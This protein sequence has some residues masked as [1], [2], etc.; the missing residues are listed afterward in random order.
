M[1][2]TVPD[3][4][5][6]CK[7]DK[8]L[9]GSLGLSSEPLKMM[10][11]EQSD[12][13][14][15]SP[16]P[17]AGD[18]S[19][20][21]EAK[22]VEH[23]LRTLHQSWEH[24]E[25]RTAL[26]RVQELF[27][28]SPCQFEQNMAHVAVLDTMEHLR[29]YLDI[30]QMGLQL[31]SCFIG[32]S[33]SM[34]DDMQQSNTVQF[35][36]RIL[37]DNTSDIGVQ[38]NGMKILS[39]LLVPDDVRIHLTLSHKTQ[40][41]AVITKD[42][43]ASMDNCD[44]LVYCTT[45]LSILLKGDR[46]LQEEFVKHQ[47]SLFLEVL[48]DHTP[49]MTLVM[50]CFRLLNTLSM[51]TSVRPLLIES[52]V[53]SKI[54]HCLK[55]W[56]SEVCVVEACF[57]V[58][59]VLCQEECVVRELT[60]QEIIM[61][62]LVPE[63]VSKADSAELQLYGL[64]IF[65]VTAERLLQ[66]QE[67]RDSPGGD[68]D[69]GSQ[70]LKVIYL[71]MSRQM[72][73]EDVQL[74]AC[75]ALTKLL[76]CKPDVYIWIGESPEG[77]QDPIH[78]LCLGA[79][80]M[81]EYNPDLFSAASG[82]I[83]YLTADNDT[84][85]QTLME[86]NTYIAIVEGLRRHL[87]NTKAV[88]A[89]CRALRGLCIFNDQHKE[90]LARYDG[91]ILPLLV[92]VL[93]THPSDCNVQSEAISTIACLADIDMI[94]HQCFVVR[95][96]ILILSAMDCFPGDEVLQEA[97]IEALAVLGGAARGAELLHSL[98]A[99]NK[100]LMCLKRFPYSAY[101]QKKGL[102]AVQ[103]LIDPR[104]LQSHTTCSDVTDV[105]KAAM[106]NFPNHLAIQKEAVVA[107]QILAERG[108]EG[109]TRSQYSTMSETL[110]DRGCHELL[111][112]ILERCDDDT[113]LHDLASECLY[114]IGIEQDLKS[115]MLVAAC[116][117]GFFTGAECL[118]EIGADVNARHGEDTPLY[119][120]V[121]NKDANMVRLLLRQEVRDV[122]AELK[123]SLEQQSHDI[124][125]MLLSH[126]GQDREMGTLLWSGYDLRDLRPEWL[127][128]SIVAHDVNHPASI[129]SKHFVMKIRK[130]EQ[131]RNQRMTLS[132]SDSNLQELY[133]HKCFRFRRNSSENQ[134]RM[135]E[136]VHE[137]RD[138][139]AKGRRPNTFP[140]ERRGR[141]RGRE[142]TAKYLT[143]ASRH[144]E[145]HVPH[146]PAGVSHPF[147][148]LRSTSIDEEEVPKFYHSEED[149]MDWKR[150]TLTGANIPFS[151]TDPRQP[152]DATSTP[153]GSDKM[154]RR[155]PGKW[156][157]K[158]NRGPL[159]PSDL[160]VQMLEYGHFTP[161]GSPAS[162]VVFEYS[163]D[164][165]TSSLMG[166]MSESG[167]GTDLDLS[168]DSKRNSAVIPVSPII[169]IDV[170][171][172]QITNLGH[173]ISG[174]ADFALRLSTLKKLDLSNNNLDCLPEQ[175]FK[176][177]PGLTHLNV[178][179]NQLSAFP[180]DSLNP[181]QL[182]CLDISTNK[183][184]VLNLSD[185]KGSLELEEMIASENKLVDFPDK[186][187]VVMPNL[188]KL[189]LASNQI[190][191]LPDSPLQL[192]DLRFLN[193]NHN[194]INC[195]PENFLTQ[196][197]K[198]ET[199][200]AANNQLDTLPSAAVAAGLLR[201]ATLR[202]SNNNITEKEP[203]FVPK[204][205]LELPNLRVLDLAGNH[206]E[207]LP[208]PLQWKTQILK[209]LVV[210]LNKITK[211]NLEGARAWSKLEKLH[212]ARNKIA[213]L[214]KEIGFLVSLQSLD[215]SHNK[216]LSSL[217][218]ELGTCIRLWEMPLDGLNLDLDVKMTRGRVQDLRIYL[219]NRLKKAQRYYRMK[220]MVVGYGGRGKTSL[221]QTLKKK[222]RNTPAPPVTVGVIVD[223]WKFERNKSVTYTLS[224]WDFAGQED[225]YSTHQCFLS[226]RTL[227][228]VVYDI[229][230]GTEEVDKLK[231]WLAN[232]HARAPGCPVII[233]GTHYDLLPAESRETTIAAF[234]AKLSDL[235]SKPGFPTISC[236]AIVDLTKE[237]PELDKLRKKLVDI[238]DEYKVR[239]QPVMGQKVPA[240][241]VK[242]GE[243]LSEE[244]RQMAR[245]VGEESIPVIRH[246]QL[247]RLVRSHNLE[248]DE[249]DELKQAVSFLHESGVLLHYD[250]TTLQMRDFYFINPGWLCRMMAQVVTVP[251][252][253]PFIKRDGIMKRNS[254]F[255]LFTGK[256]IPG[257]Q[258]FIFPTTL[259]PQYLHLLEKFEIALP[260]NEDELLFPC[261]LPTIRPA[262]EL[263]ELSRKEMAFRYYMMPF[264][265]IGFWSRLLT[266]LIVF[267][268]S[269]FIEHLLMLGTEPLA[270]YCWQEG[271]FV[272]W[273]PQAFFLV[274]GCRGDTEEVHVSVPATPE[275]A[276]LLGYIVDHI[277]S[278]VDEWYPGLTCIDPLLGHELLQRFVPCTTCTGAEPHLYLFNDLLSLS[279]KEDSVFCPQHKANVSLAQ[280][281]PDVMLTDMEAN[282]HM[283][284]GKLDF[285]ESPENLL[286]GGGFGSVYKAVYN[287]Q[288]VAIKVFAP[289]GDI[290]PH[291][292]LRQE[293]TI[294]RRLK[295][296]GVVSLVAVAQRPRYMLV[297]EFAPGR[298]LASVLHSNTS[299]SRVLQHKII[300]QVAEG[301]HYL[302][303]LMIVYRDMKPD[304]VLIFS[305][306]PDA[307]INAKITDYGISQFT[308]LS[309]LSANQGTPSYRAPEVI[310][311]ETYSFQADVFSFGILMYM[312]LTGGL[313]PFEE[314]DFQNERDKAFAD[315]SP[316]PPIT[317]RGSS[318]WPDMQ[319]LINQCMHQVPDYRPK[320]EALC[321]Q[322]NTA[323]MFCLREVLPVSVGTTVECMAC[324]QDN[325]SN[326]NVRLWVAS[327]DNEYMQLTWLGLLD[328][329]DEEQVKDRQRNKS[330]D[331]NGVGS[332]ISTALKGMGTMFRD[333][334]IL[335]V[336][337][338]T[339]E[340]VLLGTQSGKIWVFNTQVSELVHASK[341][342]QDSVLCLHLISSRCDD[343]L[344]LAGLAN[345]KIALYPV[346]EILQEPNMDPIE[347]KLGES[348]EPLCCIL[349]NNTDRKL[350][351]SCGTKII[352]M[353]TREGVAV[354][355]IINTDE[356]SGPASQP[357]LTMACGRHVFLSRRNMT[358]V[359]A[360]DIQR[361]HLKANMDI[362]EHFGLRR[363][364]ARI[365][366]MVLHEHRTLWVGTG[367]GQVAMIDVVTWT[368]LTVT[369]RHTASVRCM[370][371]VKLTGS[372][373]YGASVILSGGLGFRA[374]PDAE[375]DRDNQ[376][377]CIAVWEAD[378]PQVTKTLR[379]LNA[380][381][382]Q[383][384]QR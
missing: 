358:V 15:W 136:R 61:E 229:S 98:N 227:Y 69:R 238:V 215:V 188:H 11:T 362:S 86:K 209:E 168:E 144:G 104:L 345:G 142:I 262:F 119:C 116:S 276:R 103:V 185:L 138:K 111:F 5:H 108:L 102:M 44:L 278:L 157:R 173:L 332:E 62:T 364:D 360:W 342:L 174:G 331:M 87:T 308:T 320:S 179:G 217:P 192:P 361:D 50:K 83:Y 161:R 16:K 321:I 283:D 139:S 207:G 203:F 300:L 292:M 240:S 351:A 317:K 253:N 158:Y 197:S 89:A 301:L 356:N 47:F 169:S 250:E 59:S 75:Q 152:F 353:D 48:A 36:I 363:K 67:D 384:L 46:F 376:Y 24:D 232:I 380:K 45:S 128:P 337:Q 93:T 327:G 219:H 258:N 8:T 183:I 273:K 112:Q 277:D 271:L 285:K 167:T 244:A 328:Y 225:F 166:S 132:Q 311:G 156:R 74:V 37:H 133:R 379:D 310:R 334:R 85:C 118:I 270:V 189:N 211:L 163:S 281:A 94:R 110:V 1:R 366:A 190:E 97:S 65:T 282:F 261:R 68:I 13:G 76:E 184:G 365:T 303:R 99:V 55:M 154:A 34:L 43:A 251:E 370:L 226:N 18:T 252:I 31:L 9:S 339:A 286:G 293:A 223:E 82:A 304:N 127:L 72:A 295:H 64:K 333:G 375:I 49:D 22:E 222:V 122:Q 71:A 41:V 218:D 368:P 306:A 265:P 79:I 369:H 245:K 56:Q 329:R 372:G 100:I 352:V 78:T 338:V 17:G 241:Y 322:L 140:K 27:P 153:T 90:V 40:L 324:Q 54:Y 196:C 255:M 214:P 357:I 280:L 246:N 291:K 105:I 294:M 135:R 130:S 159:K 106:R 200:Y 124:T 383:L 257:S 2:A 298:S 221:L 21:M 381:R 335:C 318:P 302:H 213:E 91:D 239:G 123:L 58:L 143:V 84:L 176:L 28:L 126:T 194:C 290:H 51:T 96:H 195:L 191:L 101:L 325:G 242:L 319:D 205:I 81:Y 315:N 177:L 88:C 230:L 296:P 220:L 10:E 39:K 30:Q 151:P 235:M 162:P 204:F 134:M 289:I 77:K 344:V 29:S 137:G 114:V 260:R 199:L 330:Q 145:G 263:P 210:S 35:L 288:T 287:G 249:D 336:L 42:M 341:Q 247:V 264:V 201:L 299:L 121:K 243:V 25:L 354:D 216:Q 212:A 73:R 202:L 7:D 193:L 234:E 269:K 120:A 63:M 367:G 14:R 182:K 231:P 53:L 256:S 149:W 254:A 131:R 268:E 343:S 26:L 170:S 70:W 326:Q 147:S 350:L 313:H 60:E 382:Q 312:V 3:L 155:P 309:P 267:A 146:L 237:S 236:A 115:R 117:K 373:K 284:V 297:M 187:D 164:I 259:I 52:G 80:L 305:L 314:L 266:R 150:N 316:V 377:G 38:M 340:H 66:C 92:K 6:Q 206:L 374:R 113:G 180:F 33:E 172:N 32:V 347:L 359:Q 348:Y 4:W 355:K 165:E 148:V 186:L 160:P 323:E 175:M 208:P 307:V 279:E 19:Q 178:S 171:S 107:M 378:Y 95:V 233:V 23:L 125:G 346:S 129:T 141:V 349:R 371:S 228:L 109:E 274:D 181:S 20:M 198:L 12:S 275:G 57:Q 224:T 272:L 248:L